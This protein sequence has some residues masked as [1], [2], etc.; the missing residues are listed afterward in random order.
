MYIHVANTSVLQ[1]IDAA[2]VLVLHA[3]MHGLWSTSTSIGMLALA[4]SGGF[5]DRGAW[6]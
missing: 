6:S 2:T 3:K 4:S 1:S 5:R